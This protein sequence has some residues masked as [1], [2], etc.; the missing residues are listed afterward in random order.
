MNS[1]YGVARSGAEDTLEHHGVLGMRWGVRHDRR[2]QA[3]KALYKTR[4][5]ATNK[6]KS[7]SK[8]QKQRRITA[9]RE[10]WMKE[11]EKSVNRLYPRQD[12]ATNRRIARMGSGRAFFQSS[13]MG[14]YGALKYNQSRANGS[15]VARSYAR[16]GS[17]HV[18]NRLSRGTVEAQEYYQNYDARKEKKPW[19]KKK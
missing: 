1:Y 2:V 5:K 15:G 16:A 8:E 11:R 12:K 19:K 17:A 7:L 4:R 3:A 18:R 6:D 10:E 13:L 14:S 9:S